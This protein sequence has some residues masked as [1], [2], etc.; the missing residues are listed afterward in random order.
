M[1][2]DFLVGENGNLFTPRA[3]GKRLKDF[4]TLAGDNLVLTK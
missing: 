4:R 2:T 3:K 1:F